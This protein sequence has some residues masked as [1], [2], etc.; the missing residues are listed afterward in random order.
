VQVEAGT[1]TILGTLQ[2]A[3]IVCSG[4]NVHISG[5]HQGSIH[6]SNGA[7]VIVTG[8]VQGIVKVDPVAILVI[9]ENSTLEGL[10]SNDGEVIVRGLISGGQIGNGNIRPEGAGYINKP[11]LQDGVTPKGND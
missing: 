4:T 6:I 7:K 8:S 9:E 11:I 5:I 1:C 2:G 3:L 10:L